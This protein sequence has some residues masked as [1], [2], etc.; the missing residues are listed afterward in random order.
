MSACDLHEL[1]NCGI[2]NGAAQR[3]D[4]SVSRSHD[5][6]DE[7][8]FDAPVPIVPGASVIRARFGGSCRGCG[9]R[10]EPGTAI[11]QRRGDTEGWSV[12]SCCA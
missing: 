9:R 10:Y 8:E 1:S 5:F 2:C 12:V 7:E 4:Q 3:F 11:F 6:A